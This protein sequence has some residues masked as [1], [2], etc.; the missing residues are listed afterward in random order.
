MMQDISFIGVDLKSIFVVITESNGF[1]TAFAADK[2]LGDTILFLLKLADK[3]SC[4]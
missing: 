3:I 4:N 1:V 2:A